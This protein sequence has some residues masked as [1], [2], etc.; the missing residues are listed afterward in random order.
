MNATNRSTLALPGRSRT[1]SDHEFLAP[2]LEVLETPPSPVGTA[3]IVIICLLATIALAWAYIGR[4][5]IIAT[6]QGKI[7]PVGRV[8]VVQPLYG[9]KVVVLPP[10]NGTEVH[11]GDVLFQLDSAEAIADERDAETALASVHAE[12]TRRRE[13]LVAAAA[14]DDPRGARID[15]AADVPEKLRKREDAILASELGQLDA[16]LTSLRSQVRQ[17]E[18]ERNH[19]HDTLDEQASLVDTLQ[20]R[21]AMRSTLVGEN[22]GPVAG[23]IDATETLKTQRTQFA[24]QKGQL[25]DAVAG[26]DVLKAEIEKTRSTFVSDQTEKLGDAERQAEDLEQRLAKSRAELAQ[27]T[28]RSPIDGVVQA[29]VISTEGQ[30]VTA[31]E[32]VLRIVP[33]GAMLE[34]EVY[35]PN[36][37]I[38]FVHVGQPVVVKLDAF[39]FTQYG[40]VPATIVK[41]ATDAIPE[42][43]AER[44]EEDTAAALQ[45]SL[46]GGAERTQNLVFAVTLKLEQNAMPADGADVSLS[47]GMSATAEVR[48][49]SRRILAYVLSPLVEVASEAMKER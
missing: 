15:W 33:A 14:A 25:A 19:L 6:A 12:A 7:Q 27:M 24:I 47:P 37:D 38:G 48:T 45:T 39:P 49:G 30:V 3:L 28:V 42:P 9:G 5:D 32:E 43:D 26:I 44:R 10:P 21:V 16:S 1:R 22:A 23:V 20:Q 36:R 13:A 46:F 11:R 34:L 40:T 8:K 2:A 18:G 29:S 17:K 31:G 41:I 4:I 35:V